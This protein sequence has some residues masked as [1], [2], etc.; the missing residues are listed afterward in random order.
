MLVR[1]VLEAVQWPAL[2]LLH[3]KPAWPDANP[4]AHET[5]REQT[6][7]AGTGSRLEDSEALLKHTTADPRLRGKKGLERLS[8]YRLSLETAVRY[9][10]ASPLLGCTT[11]TPH[12]GILA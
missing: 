8:V 5:I 6:R 3:G 9:Q 4:L 2:E 7:E 10:R 1:P 12:Q 11:P